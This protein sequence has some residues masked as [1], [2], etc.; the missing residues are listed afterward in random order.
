MSRNLLFAFTRLFLLINLIHS[1]FGEVS[2]WGGQA[3]LALPTLAAPIGLV[4]L[5][6]WAPYAALSSPILEYA[7]IRFISGVNMLEESSDKKFG[8]D[9]KYKAY[10]EKVPCFVPFIGTKN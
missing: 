1:Y 6:P 9:P 2:L 7:L 5:G 4:V 3:L 10:K 8:D